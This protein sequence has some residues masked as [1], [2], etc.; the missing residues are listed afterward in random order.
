MFL[1]RNAP[2]HKNAQMPC[3]F[4]NGVDNRLTG[5]A[6]VIISVIQIDNPPQSLCRWRDVVTLRAKTQYRRPNIAQVDSH[7]VPGHDLRRC[8]AVA[9]K[10]LIHDPLDFFSIQIDVTAPPLFEF[11]KSGTLGVNVR[12]KVVIL[13]PQGVGGI[14]VLEIFDQMAAIE[15]SAT[16]IA[17][18]RSQPTAAGKSAGVAHW[19][20]ALYPSPV[21]QRRPRHDNGAEKFRPRGG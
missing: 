6:N 7:P 11:K 19:I 18:K 1:A 17:G 13:R 3:V 5:R 12:P 15:R 8:K 14:Q 9:D 16:E 20:L 2:G 10:Q 4:V 21:R